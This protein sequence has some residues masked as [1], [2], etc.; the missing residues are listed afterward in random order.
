M[1]WQLF[2]LVS[3]LAFSSKGLFFRTLMRQR[4]SD[5]WAQAIVFSLLVGAFSL[6]VAL[7][8]GLHFPELPLLLPNFFLLIA[9]LPMAA[10]LTFSAFQ[11][12]EASEI[13]ILIS[14]QYLWTVIA[15]FIFLNE[16]AVPSKVLGTL[17]IIAGIAITSWRKNELKINKGIFL[18]LGAAFLYGISYVNG[19]YILQHLDAPSFGFYASILPALLLLLIR[20]QVIKKMSFYLIPKNGINVLT[21]SFL[22]TVATLT[23]YFAYQ[24]GRNA[25]QITP[26]SATSPIITVM[27]ATLFLRE[28]K[29]LTNKFLGAAAVV[30]GT[31]LIL[32]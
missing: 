24:L 20:P 5:P 12:L 31:A 3:V 11:L 26:L 17:L 7:P 9:I 10:F 4:N 18:I 8:Q 13:G 2:I 29:S 14:S 6:L 16:P 23:L 15:S 25:S 22:D 32:V 28:R 27:L 30:I 1:T 21:T 19:F